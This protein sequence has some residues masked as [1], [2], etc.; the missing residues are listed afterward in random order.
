MNALFLVILGCHVPYLFYSGKEALLIIID[1][2][3]RNSISLVLSKKLLNEN[4]AEIDA[5]PEL[6]ED[7]KSLPGSREMSKVRG[8]DGQMNKS[9]ARGQSEIHNERF[10]ESR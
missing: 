7:E 8:T 6:P 3:M 1:E 10:S 9:K 2:I 4:A 5:M